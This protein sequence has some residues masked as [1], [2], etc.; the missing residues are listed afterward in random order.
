M[1]AYQPSRLC[2]CCAASCRPAAGGHAD[3]QRHR[4]L[5]AR[6][7]RDRGRVVHDLVER[8]QAEVAGHD[9]DDRP[10]AGHRRAD[11]GADEA[12]LGQ[13]R[14]A[15]ALRAELLEQALGHGVAAAVLADVLAHHEACAGRRAARRGSPACRPR[16]RSCACGAFMAPRSCTHLVHQHEALEVL[17]RLQR[18]GL[19]EGDRG[20]DLGR[21]PRPRCAAASAS[22][23]WW[24]ACHPA[25]AAARSGRA[26]SSPRSRRACGRPGC[27][28]SNARG[29]GRCGIRGSTARCAARGCVDRAPRRG[30]HRAPGPCRRPARPACGRPAALRQMSVSASASSSGMPMA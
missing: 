14:V 18:A 5:P 23:S 26:A 2:E 20:V 11:A 29:S 3:H 1:C 9:L 6:H 16:G 10:Q 21:R 19:G 13:R 8:E 24:F 30:L 27:R 28:T 12:V 22:L 4:E 17:D 15:D 7:V 25:R